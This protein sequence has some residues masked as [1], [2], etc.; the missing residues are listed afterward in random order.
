[1]ARKQLSQESMDAALKAIQDGNGV[2]ETA[3]MYNLPVEMLRH[4][5]IGAVPANC[6]PGPKPVLNPDEEQALYDYCLKM[7][8][9]GFSLSRDDVMRMAFSI[10]RKVGQ[11][12][13]FSGERAWL[14]GFMSRHP[15]LTL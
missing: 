13:P 4:H 9:M 1:M 11:S 6:K 5:V 7:A 14:A 3:R 8:D 2:R 15:R 12:H 10:V